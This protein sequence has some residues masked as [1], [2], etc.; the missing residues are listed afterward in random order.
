MYVKN[1][2]TGVNSS[3]EARE[4]YSETKEVTS[5]IIHESERMGVELE[6]ISEDNSRAG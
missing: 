5:R 6:R 2:L 4:F 3:K 1:L